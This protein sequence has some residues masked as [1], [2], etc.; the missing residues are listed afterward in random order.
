MNQETITTEPEI[1]IIND[2]SPLD[3]PVKERNYTQHKVTDAQMMEDLEE[4]TFQPPSFSDIDD[5][6]SEAEPSRP[7]NQNYSELDGKE[8]TMGAK[9][10]VEMAIDLYEK[11]C[12]L[13]GK[14]PEMSEAKLDRLISEG[15]IDSNIQIPTESGDLAVKDFAREYNDSIKDAFSVSDD[16]K[17][18]IKPPLE[19]IFKKRGIG[20]TD[21][22]LV[23]YYLITDLGTKGVQA[24]MLRKTT[25]G[26]LDTLKENTLALRENQAPK[27]PKPEP[28]RDTE[29]KPRNINS[30]DQEPIDKDVYTDNIG[31]FVSSYNEKPKTNPK[32]RKPKTNLEEQ[33]EYFEPEEMDNGVFSVLNDNG[34]FKSESI[35]DGNMPSFG[36]P[37][38]LAGINNI[39]KQ[40]QQK[41]TTRRRTTKTDNNRVNAKRPIYRKPRK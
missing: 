36:D 20:M 23:G 11:G 13:L 40:S 12:G 7:F 26:I 14:L 24:F 16:F 35:V 31:D 28:F 30:T 15:E 6:D 4:P 2:F 17:E 41:T 38:I 37:E 22:Q 3:A 27:T 8:K 34:G 25:N 10:M 29:S 21:E 18:K 5:D 39:E 1:E 32:P 33:L 19:R 9:M